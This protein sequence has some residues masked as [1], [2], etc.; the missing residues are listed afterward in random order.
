MLLFTF[1]I[2]F[3]SCLTLCSWSYISVSINTSTDQW[4]FPSPLYVVLTHLLSP[5][6]LSVIPLSV[7]SLQSTF[8]LWQSLQHLKQI[9][10]KVRKHSVFRF[11]FTTKC[12]TNVRLLKKSSKFKQNLVNVIKN[13]L[14]F[15]QK[16]REYHYL[17]RYYEL[18]KRITVL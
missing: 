17:Y 8:K 13:I 12:A 1:R 5:R 10:R 11:G 9:S 15:Q 14:E 7:S 16:M 3:S 6:F 4:F 18:I 2:K